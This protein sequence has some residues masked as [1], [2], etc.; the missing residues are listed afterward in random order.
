M[1]SLRQSLIGVSIRVMKLSKF[2]LFLTILTGIEATAYGLS[3]INLSGELDVA[4][5]LYQLPTRNQGDLAFSIPSFKLD[6]EVPLRDGNELL[7]QLESAEYRD[8]SSKRFETT[9]KQAYI[10]LTSVLS[11]RSE[12]RYGLIPDLWI[13]L[14]KEQWDYDF[15]GT[16]SYLPMIKYKYSS[17]SDLGLMFQ[18]VLPNDLGQW[19][20]L[21]TNGEGL[22]SNEVGSRKQFQLIANLTKAAPYYLMLSYAHGNY[23]NYDESFSEKQRILIHLSYDFDGS[24]IALECFDMKDPANVISTLNMGGGVDVTALAGSSV[25]GQGASLIG[26]LK[27]DEKWNIFLRAEWLNPVKSESEKYLQDGILGTSYAL[28]EDV[29]MALSW[30]YTHYSAQFSPSARDASQVV[31]GTRVNF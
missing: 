15:W 3:D 23:D 1:N 19:A 20:F 17:W 27:L 7:F 21:V 4:T 9:L 12:I 25:S 30:E 18:S 29:L 22:E 11:P 8:N 31:L 5:T 26:K 10:N 24:L 13:E 6:A 28:S 16:A 14:E 2:F